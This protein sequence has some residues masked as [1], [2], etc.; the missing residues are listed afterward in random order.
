MLGLRAR[1]PLHVG[2][3][4]SDRRNIAQINNSGAAMGKYRPAHPIRVAC[5]LSDGA[6]KKLVK[7]GRMSTYGAEVRQTDMQADPGR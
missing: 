4:R 5:I 2:A 1:R 6:D 3:I 7:P